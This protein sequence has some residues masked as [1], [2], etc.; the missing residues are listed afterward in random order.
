MPTQEL[1]RPLLFFNTVGTHEFIL[2]FV[3]YVSEVARGSGTMVQCLVFVVRSFS[4]A[5]LLCPRPLSH[6]AGGVSE[7]GPS[8]TSLC[9]LTQG[10]EMYMLPRTLYFIP[11]VDLSSRAV[12]RNYTLPLVTELSLAGLLHVDVANVWRQLSSC[13]R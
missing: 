8:A 3:G 6:L 7:G 12:R 5:A 13:S 4:S 9:S 1:D 10:R 2:D 11:A